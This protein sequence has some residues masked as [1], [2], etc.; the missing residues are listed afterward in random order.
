MTFKFHYNSKIYDI[1][2]KKCLSNYLRSRRTKWLANLR[3]D[4]T[5]DCQICDLSVK[6]AIKQ[7]KLSVKFII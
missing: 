7:T 6:F 2:D 3:Y 4:R 1:T 5:K